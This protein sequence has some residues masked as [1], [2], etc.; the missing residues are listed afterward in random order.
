MTSMASEPSYIEWKNLKFIIMEAPKDSNLHVFIKLFKK[1]NVSNVVRISEP[2]YSKASIEEAGI[3][4]HVKII[5]V[6]LKLK[7]NTFF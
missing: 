3:A 1:Y 6:I 7:I 4:L 5:K 2:R